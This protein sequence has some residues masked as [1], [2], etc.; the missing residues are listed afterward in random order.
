MTNSRTLDLPIKRFQTDELLA[1]AKHSIDGAYLLIEGGVAVYALDKDGELMPSPIRVLMGG[2]LVNP[3]LFTTRGSC[4]V[5]SGFTAKAT[6]QV[7][8]YV[9]TLKDLTD[10]SV[11]EH[12]R[13]ERTEAIVNTL[14]SSTIQRAEETNLYETALSELTE[15][16][17]VLERENA[18]LL[19]E[20]KQITQSAVQRAVLTEMRRLQTQVRD[21]TDEKRRGDREIIERTNEAKSAVDYAKSVTDDIQ[22]LEHLRDLLELEVS[23]EKKFFD[24]L[25]RIFLTLFSA[26]SHAL[27]NLGVYGLGI[28]S[29][30]SPNDLS[31]PHSPAK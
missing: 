4:G 21:L 22:K 16:K 12:E 2:E 8:A 27:Q 11:S 15:Q 29:K 31:P 7:S 25:Q 14:A 24:E 26:R 19:S 3:E 5:N 9:I 17:R 6:T 13:R 30:V 10:P 28:L 1:T 20:N 23:D 18:Q